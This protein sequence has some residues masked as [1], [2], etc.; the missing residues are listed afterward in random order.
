MCPHCLNDRV[1]AKR[2]PD[3]DRCALHTNLGYFRDIISMKV[4]ALVSGGK[5]SC[6][7]MME[8]VK[9]GHEIIGLAHLFPQENGSK[10]TAEIDSFMFQS[11]GSNLVE[12]IASC[13]DVPLWTAAIAGKPNTTDLMYNTAVDGDEVEDMYQLLLQVKVLFQNW[14]LNC[15]DQDCAERGS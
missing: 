15:F 4:V 6:F 11:V 2:L 7:A 8:C 1:V 10:S 12:S 14:W 3:P 13:M 5:D 9:Y